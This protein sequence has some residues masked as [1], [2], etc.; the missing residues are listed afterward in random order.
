[1][2][3]PLTPI[4]LLI[5]GA[6][7]TGTSPASAAAATTT[8]GNAAP[9]SLVILNDSTWRQ[10]LEGEWMIQFHAPWCPACRAMVD[11]WNELARQSRQLDVKV[12]KADVTV[13]PA[14]SGRFF[15]TALPTI[16]HVKD[17]EFRQYRGPRDVQTLQT[18]I[19]DRKWHH[20]EPISTWKHPDSLQMTVVAYFFRLSHTLKEMNVYLQETYHMPNWLTYALFALVTITLGAIIGLV[21]VCIVDYIAPPRRKTFEE[22]QQHGIVHDFA[23]EDLDV[24]DP[25]EDGDDDSS[26]D[27][28]KNSA[29]DTEEE[30]EEAERK[31]LERLVDEKKRAILSGELVVKP[32]ADN[33][34]RNV[35]AEPVV[36][37]DEPRKASGELK[38]RRT[39][40]AD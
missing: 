4:L 28:E 2:R 6:C 18:M 25:L 12:A 32:K 35:A 22:L 10:V 14:L 7:L 29:P 40:K 11:G 34:E 20:M 36:G 19:A 8:S 24:D 21:F 13:S 3:H 30:E 27:G 26:S 15:I 16:L 17:G 38:K 5:V 9:R 31:R 39:R 1:M 33:S 37:G 23:A